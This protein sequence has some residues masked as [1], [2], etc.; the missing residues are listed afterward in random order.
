MGAAEEA[1]G[2]QEGLIG[3]RCLACRMRRAW[4]IQFHG[5]A[6]ETCVERAVRGHPIFRRHTGA[7]M[8]G[9]YSKRRLV[10]RIACSR[11]S[12]ISIACWMVPVDCMRAGLH[13]CASPTCVSQFQQAALHINATWHLAP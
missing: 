8:E 6:H 4:R 12:D 13:T 9:K 3:G 1:E 11:C 7:V 5:C 2:R 10:Q